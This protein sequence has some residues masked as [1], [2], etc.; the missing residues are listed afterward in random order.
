MIME[1]TLHNHK[2]PTTVEEFLALPVWAG[3]AFKLHEKPDGSRVRVPHQRTLMAYYVPGD[4]VTHVDGWR[5]AWD[6]L[7]YGRMEDR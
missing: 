2:A 3:F 4:A 7:N 5:L 6:G 1:N